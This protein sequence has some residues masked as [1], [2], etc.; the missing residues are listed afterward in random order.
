[1]QIVKRGR[2][3]LLKIGDAEVEYDP[4]FR[5]FLQTK[6]SNPHYKPEVAAQ[7][8]LVNFCVTEQGLEN[9]LLA[10]VSRRG[11][12]IAILNSKFAGRALLA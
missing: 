2:S 10:L 9:Q 11:C 3:L 12:R 6:L 8:T 4:R 1:M 5:L 7:T